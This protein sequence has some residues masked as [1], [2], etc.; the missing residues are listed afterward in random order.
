MKDLAERTLDYITDHLRQQFPEA[1]TERSEWRDSGPE[2]RLLLASELVPCRTTGAPIM[3]TFA[4]NSVDVTVADRITI[5]APDVVDLS[6]EDLEE[7]AAISATWALAF[8]S[9]IAS[10]GAFWVRRR[11]ARF[12]WLP[13]TELFVPQDAEEAERVSTGGSGRVVTGWSPWV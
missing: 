7:D 11:E 5:E 10:F 13:S 8:C 4:H 2:V 9:R 3:L 12:F 1:F 6:F